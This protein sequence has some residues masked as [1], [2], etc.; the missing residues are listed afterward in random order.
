M[1]DTAHQK[2]DFATALALLDMDENVQKIIK[3]TLRIFN[4]FFN[5]KI[6]MPWSILINEVSFQS[7]EKALI[8][9]NKIK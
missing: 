7:Q 8:R 6:W 3:K 2:G 4:P 5:C 1:C 9:Q